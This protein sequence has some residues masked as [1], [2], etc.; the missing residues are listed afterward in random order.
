[1]SECVCVCLC[2]CVMK[3]NCFKIECNKVFIEGA[4]WLIF[5]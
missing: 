2:A 5:F 1:M 3:I 4:C